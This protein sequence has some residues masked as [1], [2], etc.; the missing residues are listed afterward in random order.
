MQE[1]VTRALMECIEA[2]AARA[3]ASQADLHRT[4]AGLQMEIRS[5]ESALR[6][7]IQHLKVTLLKWFLAFWLGAVLLFAAILLTLLFG[8]AA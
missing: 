1:K 5:V 7:E 4:A 6:G 8:R 3:G 2:A